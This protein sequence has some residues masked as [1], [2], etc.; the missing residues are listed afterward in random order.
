V[1][2]A[3]GVLDDGALINQS[4]ERFRTVLAAKVHGAWNLDRLT[5]N[6][7]LECFVLFSSMTSLLGPT[8][9]GNHA[10][11]NAFLDAL[12]HD[13]RRRGQPGIT[14]NWGAWSE[15]GA[16]AREDLRVK[17]HE[18]G[19]SLI[20][21][22]QGLAAL[23]RILRID[24]P[25]AL[26]WPLNWPVFARNVP[27]HSQ[28]PLMKELREADEVHVGKAW[29]LV[30][31]EQ[32]SLLPLLDNASAGQRRALTTAFVQQIAAKNMGLDV[33]EID[34]NQDLKQYGLDSLMAVSM[35]GSLAT[36]IGRELPVT[37]LFDYPSP[38]AV[39]DFLLKEVL[40]DEDSDHTEISESELTPSV[41]ADLDALS[42]EELASLLDA[43]LDDSAGAL[44]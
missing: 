11:A 5:A 25:Q 6:Q 26:V 9:Q 1:V 12:A 30:A 27:S 24:K 2:H 32:S 34:P 35:R 28:Q 31:V 42:T 13:R 41:V 19:V 15:V 16:A 20:A 14:I 3:A 21:P 40:G 36:A 18:Q 23:E 29:S 17:M 43:E 22:V 37:L 39:A 4:W 7:P 38:Q 33:T 10:A 44:H 8:G